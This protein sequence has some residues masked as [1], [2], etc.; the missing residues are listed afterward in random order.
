MHRSSGTT[1]ISGLPGWESSK[2]K[3]PKVEQ[4]GHDRRSGRPTKHDTIVDPMSVSS[5]VT[6][7]PHNAVPWRTTDTTQR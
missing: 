2:R 3:K 1:G 7:D 5:L 4:Q 6:P